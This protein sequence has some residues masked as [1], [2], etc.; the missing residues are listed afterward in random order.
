MS[1]FIEQL[2]ASFLA[3]SER[4]LALI[5][6][7]TIGVIGLLLAWF[8]GNRVKSITKKQLAKRMDD[9]LLANFLARLLK[10]F[11][12]IGGLLFLLKRIGWGDAAAG[13][14]ATAGVGAFVIGFALRDI[15]ENFLAGIIMAFQR[16]FRVGDTIEVNGITGVIRGLSLRETHVKTFD[17]KDVF[18]P[19][20]LILKNPL[21]NYTID[22]FMRKDITINLAHDADVDKA[23]EVVQKVVLSVEG[24]LTGAKSPTISVTGIDLNGLQ[25]Q[26]YYWVNTDGSISGTVVRKDIIKQSVDGLRK[27]GFILPHAQLDVKTLNGEKYR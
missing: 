25:L 21:F 23:I 7:L 8:I 10:V 24:V 19:N 4:I 5:P 1:Q 27:N 18:I 13:I 26:V 11:I 6:D 15:G 9:P 22:G 17:G 16:P 2:K 14:M 20:G 12:V 3:E